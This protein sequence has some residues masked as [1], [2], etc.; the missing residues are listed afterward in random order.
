MIKDPWKTVLRISAQEHIFRFLS[1]FQSFENNGEI[2]ILDHFFLEIVV[3][4][5][6]PLFLEVVK[7]NQCFCL[8]LTLSSGDHVLSH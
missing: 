4:D 7:L 8:R 6:Y 1:N 3:L 2:V 5:H